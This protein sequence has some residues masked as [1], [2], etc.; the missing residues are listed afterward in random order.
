MSD[1]VIATLPKNS[2]E[3]V[4]VAVGEFKGHQ[5]FSVRVWADKPDGTSVPTPKGITCGIGLL[6]GII[7]ALEEALDHVQKNEVM[8]DVR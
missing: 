1:I 2:R 4:R 5:L 8:T 7:K 6:P 3:H